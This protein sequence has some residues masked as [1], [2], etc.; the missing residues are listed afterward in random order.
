MWRICGC[1][2][3]PGEKR[4]VT[5]EPNVPGYEIPA[6]LVCGSQPGKTLLITAGIHSGEYPS[7]P[8]VI[9]T[10]AEIDAA[11]L[12][13]NVVL[14]HCVNTS[15]FWAKS[16]AC[17]PEDGFN[18]NGDYPGKAAGT[19]GERIA[20]Y[21]VRELFPRVDF[22]LDLHSGGGTEPL[23]PCLFYP[24]AERVT[25]AALEAAKALD[26]PYLI[27]SSATKG[28]YSYAANFHDVPGLLL[29]RGC[30]GNCFP[31]WIEAYRR[32]IRL[33]MNHLGLYDL[34]G[35]ADVCEKKIYE[36]AVYLTAGEAGLWYPAVR[37]GQAVCAGALLGRV[38]DF[39][40]NPVAEYR[41][42]ADG[43]VFYYTSGLAVN[44]GDALVAYGLED[45][46]G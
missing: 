4:Q 12:R 25:K 24:K 28:E 1:S 43:M 13:G 32:D 46:A 2:L 39:Y 8:A 22:I 31:E 34:D 42:E 18:L 41:A 37:E 11:R 15:G 21:F 38:E 16:P 36:R 17:I 27:A 10:A 23:T 19:T 30:S 6:T 9:R 5:I 20:D 44:R 29:E 33:L 7:I 26:I 45:A 14:M 35:A 3:Q 40:G